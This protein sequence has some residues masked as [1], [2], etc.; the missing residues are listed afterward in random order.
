[1]NN[2][3]I[4]HNQNG[5]IAEYSALSETKARLSGADPM[6]VEHLMSVLSSIAQRVARTNTEVDMP[7]EDSSS[8]NQDGLE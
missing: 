5:E 7:D 3:H 2:S 8:F 4:Q 1:M 6:E